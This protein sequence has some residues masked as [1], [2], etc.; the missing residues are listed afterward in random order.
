MK[1]T[2]GR[3][4]VRAQEGNTKPGKFLRLPDRLV[5]EAALMHQNTI[6]GAPH[7]VGELKIAVVVAEVVPESCAPAP[8]PAYGAD[9]VETGQAPAPDN[10][11]AFVEFGV[12]RFAMRSWATRREASA[13]KYSLAR[14]KNVGDSEFRPPVFSPPAGRDTKNTA[15]RAHQDADSCRRRR[16]TSIRAPDPARYFRPVVI[17]P[18]GPRFSRLRMKVTLGGKGPSTLHCEALSTTTISSMGT[19]CRA[20]AATAASTDS[21]KVPMYARIFTRLFSHSL[22]ATVDWANLAG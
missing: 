21:L 10:R 5:D 20:R 9:G 18:L 16:S 11:V 17:A 2:A 13:A 22:L 15:N 8:W 12:R 7:T 6:A 1:V 4:V 14:D 19:V 3:R